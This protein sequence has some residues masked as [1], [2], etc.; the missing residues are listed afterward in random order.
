MF[1]AHWCLASHEREYSG[2]YVKHFFCHVIVVGDFDLL[3]LL[4]KNHAGSLTHFVPILAELLIHFQLALIFSCL[5]NNTELRCYEVSVLLFKRL[6]CRFIGCSLW[7]VIK[8][9][10]KWREVILSLLSTHTSNKNFSSMGVV[11]SCC[12]LHTAKQPKVSAFFSFSRAFHV[13][14]NKTQKVVK[15]LVL[16]ID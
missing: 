10:S 14:F 8:T 9:M 3:L 12:L 5:L 15:E 4:G 7:A 6:Q 16:F 11:E 2:G 1:S 13:N